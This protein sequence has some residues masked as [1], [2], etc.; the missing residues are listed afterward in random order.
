MICLPVWLVV[1]DSTKF[2]CTC[3]LICLTVWVVAPVR[4]F[5]SLVSLHLSP[6]WPAKPGYVVVF[7]SFDLRMSPN[8]MSP[9]RWYPALRMSIFT[10]LPSFVSWFCSWCPALWM[11]VFTCFPLCASQAGWWCPALRMSLLTLSPPLRS[12]AACFPDVS[13]YLS[14]FIC[15][16]V[17][18]LVS[19]S[20]RMSLFT[21]FASF[22]KKCI[23]GSG[24]PQFFLER[25]PPVYWCWCPALLVTL[26]TCL[27]SFVSQCAWWCPAVCL[28]VLVSL[29]FSRYA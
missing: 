27:P 17:W 29:Y 15:L 3:P 2:V 24:G 14:P 6:V 22:P 20:L 19:G 11:S 18:P 5:G 8:S 13:L 10:C 7:S 16:P 12:C 1:S 25:R 21:C 26:F 23:V 4:L 28:S 9:N